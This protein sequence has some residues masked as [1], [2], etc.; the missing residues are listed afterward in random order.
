MWGQGP[1]FPSI[2]AAS[3]GFHSHSHSQTNGQTEKYSQGMEKALQC[4]TS[5]NSSLT[6]IGP[7]ISVGVCPQLTSCGI[8]ALASMFPFECVYRYQPFGF[9]PYLGLQMSPPAA[10]L[11]GQRRLPDVC[12]PSQRTSSSMSSRPKGG[13]LHSRPV[14]SGSYFNPAAFRLHLCCP[15]SL[16]YFPSFMSKDV[17][18]VCF[19]LPRSL[20]DSAWWFL[21]LYRVKSLLCS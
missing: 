4:I 7:D 20:P 16:F 15:M 12:Q 13:A 2:P 3:S 6:P 1:P 5:M 14:G 17:P 19:V 10:L 18:W 8:P 21:L 9:S 11:R